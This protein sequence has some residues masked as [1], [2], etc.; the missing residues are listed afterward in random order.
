MPR[1]L[2]DHEAKSSTACSSHCPE[3][4]ETPGED[5]GVGRRVKQ[6]LDTKKNVKKDLPSWNQL[7]VLEERLSRVESGVGLGFATEVERPEATT[8]YQ[9]SEKNRIDVVEDLLGIR[10]QFPIRLRHTPLA[11]WICLGHKC[12]GSFTRMD[13]MRRHISKS[14]DF[15]HVLLDEL[16]SQTTC[17]K[18][19]KNLETPRKLVRHRRLNHEEAMKRLQFEGAL[20][21]F[22]DWRKIGLRPSADGDG[23][24]SKQ[25]LLEENREMPR[26]SPRKRRKTMVISSSVSEDGTV[27]HT[28]M[29]VGDSDSHGAALW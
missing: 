27:Y 28:P 9:S 21:V 29:S 5:L 17:A 4:R 16:I 1:G 23:T 20:A 13:N 25:P 8:N 14:E 18:C 11:E 7:K 26:K 10:Y 3:P 19:N 15:A 6:P 22:N 2:T 12:D 24:S